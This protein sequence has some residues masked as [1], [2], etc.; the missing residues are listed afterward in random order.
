M[1]SQMGVASVGADGESRRFR[2]CLLVARRGTETLPFVRALHAGGFAVLEREPDAVSVQLVVSAEFDLVAWASD[3]LSTTD[4]GVM[5]AAQRAG[6]PFIS[7]FEAATPAKVS[8]CLR[9]GADACLQLDAD[10]RV[11]VAQALAVLRRRGKVEDG[12]E[13][14]V[15]QIGDLSVDVIRCEVERAGRYI[16]LTASEFRIV[17][18]MARRAGRV[19]KAHEVLNA[20]SDEFEYRPREAQEV[21]KVYVRRI[22][23]KLEPTEAEPRYLVTVRGFGY[24][25][26]GGTPAREHSR[27]AGRTA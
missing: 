21:F 5:A 12:E 2:S 3:S 18:Y 20:V 22:R 27:A 9:A 24:R 7:L 26:E 25:L 14:G 6:V 4:Y 13:S 8:D 23:R 19:V 10:Q 11:V 16:P 17:E 1:D 15:L